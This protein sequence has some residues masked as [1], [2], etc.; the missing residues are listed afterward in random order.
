MKLQGTELS[1]AERA[2][3]L[4]AW[5]QASTT[6]G[7]RELDAIRYRADHP[8]SNDLTT[9]DKLNARGLLR[10]SPTDKYSIGVVAL[11]LLNDDTALAALQ[12][13]ERIYEHLRQTYLEVLREPV[14]ID[15]IA[16]TLNIDSIRLYDLLHYLSEA[17]GLAHLPTTPGS[18][19]AKL[20]ISETILKH[21]TFKERL[22][23]WTDIV[24]R[25]QPPFENSIEEE[26]A[27]LGAATAQSSSQKPRSNKTLHGN[28]E[29]FSSEREQ[30]LGAAIAV[31]NARPNA[32]K[33]NGKYRGKEIADQIEA[34]AGTLWPRDLNPPLGHDKITRLVNECLKKLKSIE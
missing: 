10:G 11:P 9:I 28:A 33:H 12:D 8:N 14:S 1:D 27:N 29:R 5:R 32:C 2:L 6:P 16:K 22:A 15:E 20:S 23:W 26:I 7:E 13:M 18:A 3:L 4:D 25:V 31:M 24:L 19:G 17:G 34:V 30:I 21:K